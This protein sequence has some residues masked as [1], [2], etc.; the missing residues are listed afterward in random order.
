MKFLI[1]NHYMQ[2][3]AGSEINAMQLALG[4]RSLGHEADI[5]TINLRNPIK[6][7]VEEN[8]IR[9]FELLKSDGIFFNYDVLWAHHAPVLAYLLFH[10][11]INDT[12]LIFSS[13]SS[14]VPLEAP[15]VFKDEIQ[16]FLSHNLENTKVLIR[17]GVP[18][19]K[20]HYFPN[21]SP[22]KY[23]KWPPKQYPQKPKNIAVISNHVP[24]ELRAFAE[25][26]RIN[27]INVDFIGSNDQPIFVDDQLIDNYDLIITIGKT[28]IYC[29][30][31]AVPVYCYD[32]FGGPGYLNPDNFII[33]KDNNFSGRG[34]D[35]KLTGGDLFFDI[36]NN[37]KPMQVNLQ[38][39]FTECCKEFHLEKNLTGIINILNQV[40]LLRINEFRERNSLSERVVDT[41]IEKVKEVHRLESQVVDLERTVQALKT[42]AIEKDQLLQVLNAQLT[43]LDETVLALNIELD[44][45][46]TEVLKYALSTSWRITKPFRKIIALFK[47]MK[48]F[49]L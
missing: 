38:F 30:A 7:I 14:F 9:V 8:G 28:V 23:F 39:L 42:Q 27:D 47:K 40:P 44:E 32:Y 13:L 35:R 31:L 33:A 5:A 41:Y 48:C 49:L 45:K 3:F 6:K 17:N 26:S 12:K 4:L 22:E 1:L 25:I 24:E 46:K 10:S 16:L 11:N 20:I 19:E 29:F 34:F 36:V 2:F 15:P 37:Y 43:M 18:S 21:Y